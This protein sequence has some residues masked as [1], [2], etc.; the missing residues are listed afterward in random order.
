MATAPVLG[1]HE[2]YTKA[3][4]PDCSLS[5]VWVYSSE[6]MVG[7]QVSDK[8]GTEA[9]NKDEAIVPTD[10]N[11]ICDDDLRLVLKPLKKGVIFTMVRLD[12]HAHCPCAEASPKCMFDN[13]AYRCI[14]LPWHA[15]VVHSFHQAASTGSVMASHCTC[16]ARTQQGSVTA[17]LRLL[18]LRLHA[19]PPRAADLRR[20]G[21]QRTP[22]RLLHE[23]YGHAW[24]VLPRHPRVPPPLLHLHDKAAHGAGC[25]GWSRALGGYGS[26]LQQRCVLLFHVDIQ[27]LCG[28][29]RRCGVQGGVVDDNKNRAL[30]Q[31]LF[32]KLLGDKFG[33]NVLPGSIHSSLQRS[34]GD[35]ASAKSLKAL[36]MLKG[37]LEGYA[38]KNAGTRSAGGVTMLMGLLTACMKMSATQVLS[39]QSSQ[40]VVVAWLGGA[41]HALHALDCDRMISTGTALQG[42][43]GGGSA[44]AGGE[45]SFPAATGGGGT[46]GEA[47]TAQGVLITGCQSHETSADACPSGDP[48]KAFGALTNALT[49]SVRATKKNNPN[50]SVSY[51]A[52][53]QD[54][55]KVLLQAKFTQNPCLECED[56]DVDKPFIC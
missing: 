52:L 55:R 8:D 46:A 40:S 27:V 53:V 42:G 34:F 10:M 45:P 37:V 6:G 13:F 21:P 25:V 50:A 30:P 48:K 26:L 16:A 19:G 44:A 2:P 9:D 23:P 33:M 14:R 1:S 5:L 15:L 49:T 29:W 54:V 41:V 22:R 32:C 24:H 18:P 39:D 7:V 47:T 38:K 43:G 11:L 31:N 51:K 4:H 3:V 12:P 35:D 20:Q 17:G 28:K 36:G 56:G